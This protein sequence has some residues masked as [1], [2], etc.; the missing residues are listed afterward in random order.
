[1]CRCLL[2]KIQQ[3]LL[4][5]LLINRRLLIGRQIFVDFRAVAILHRHIARLHTATGAFITDSNTEERLCSH[6]WHV[7]CGQKVLETVANHGDCV[8][9]WKVD[10]F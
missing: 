6:L 2:V 4:I 9:V 1:M 5:V 7:F 3:R 8:F 10:V